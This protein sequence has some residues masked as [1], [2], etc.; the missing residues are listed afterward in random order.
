MLAGSRDSL[1]TAY[2]GDIIGI[3]CSANFKIGDTLSTSGNFTFLPMPQFPPEVVAKIRPK[4]VSKKKAFD[5]GMKQISSEGAVQVLSYYKQTIA[6]PLIAAVGKMQF[7]VV[8]FRLENEYKV[9]TTLE[10]LPYKYGS[11]LVGDPA[12]FKTS[13][14]VVLA[15]NAFKQNIVLY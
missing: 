8:Q 9:K 5:K 3:N 7:D 15:V 10:T 4:D 6:D 12:T 1:D 14:S 11:W 2:P 13:S